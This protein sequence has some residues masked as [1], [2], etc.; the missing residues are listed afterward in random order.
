MRQCLV[1]VTVLLLGACSSDPQFA[2]D[3]PMIRR[4]QGNRRSSA[5]R[6][7]WSPCDCTGKQGISA[8]DSSGASYGACQCPL[9]LGRDRAAERECR[10]HGRSADQYGGPSAGSGASTAPPA[11]DAGSRPD[12]NGPV[13]TKPD[14]PTTTLLAM[15]RSPSSAIEHAERSR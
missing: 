9:R 10:R 12:D 7:R 14:E 2:E 11:P 5:F 15:D 13:Q 1:C 8:C 6:A 3:R 4:P